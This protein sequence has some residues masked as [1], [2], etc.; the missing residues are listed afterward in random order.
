[1]TLSRTSRPRQAGY[2]LPCAKCRRY[3]PADLDVC[4]ICKGRERVSPNVAPLRRHLKAE[5]IAQP[6]PNVASPEL[7]REKLPN[8]TTS[9]VTAAPVEVVIAPVVIS[10]ENLDPV[11]P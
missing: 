7:Q 10:E 2:G 1:M 5:A 3:F 4:P 9:P 8:E 11:E 6:N